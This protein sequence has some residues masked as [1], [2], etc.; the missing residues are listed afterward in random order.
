MKYSK[1]TKHL[2]QNL[3]I[4][5]LGIVVFIFLGEAI[6]RLVVLSSDSLPID[7]VSD[8]DLNYR[9]KPNSRGVSIHGIHYQVN[10]QGLRDYD[11][12]YEKQKDNFRILL[13]GDSV[14]L[15][16]GVEAA[17]TFPKILERML[18]SKQAPKSYEVI[19]A[20][21]SGY[22][23]VQELRYLKKEGLKYSPDLIVVL[24]LS[25][26][27]SLEPSF[28]IVRDN[29]L[30]NRR[31]IPLPLSL[32]KMLRKSSLYHFFAYSYRQLKYKYR[33]QSGKNETEKEFSQK[34]NRYQRYILEMI[35]ISEKEKLGL[36]FVFF[37]KSNQLVNRCLAREQLL[38]LLKVEDI[39]FL[40]LTAVIKGHNN[41]LLYLPRDS[42]H[43]NLKLHQIMAETIY[44]EL[45]TQELTRKSLRDNF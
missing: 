6:T 3:T 36:L 4:L 37:P 23:T 7:F 22:N 12:P 13:L 24:F 29:I 9:M 34:W 32:T 41:E 10:S 27:V 5:L 14:A 28:G 38:S 21:V 35:D 31:A 11:Y 20:G 8:D 16:Y 45:I 42:V 40:D 18:N 26:D 19:N 39:S 1:K 43:P 30:L 44:K 15:G 25:D 2:L 17:D 33:T